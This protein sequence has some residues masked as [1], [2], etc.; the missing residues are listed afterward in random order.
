LKQLEDRTLPS[1]AFAPHVDYPVGS[2]PISVAVGDF[3]GNGK[4]DLA[5]VN[6]GSNSV[7][8]LMGNGDGTFQP[9]VNYTVGS[10]PRW[11][12]V[13][14]FR[15]DGKL[16]LAVACTGSNG[17]NI[18]LGNGDGTFQPAQ[19]YPADTA[20]GAVAVGDFNGD[21]NLD[22]AV[23]NGGGDVSILLGNGDGTFQ[24]PR[25]FA[26]DGSP[27]GIAVADL[28]HDGKLDVVTANQTTGDFSVLLGSGDGTLQAAQNYSVG[29][30]LV[31]VVV[32][33][34]NGDGKLDIA[35]AKADI[36]GLG[37]DSV[38]L[39]LGNGD[40]TFQS[41]SYLSGVT[42]PRRLA[43]GDFTGDG[44]EDLAVADLGANDV[45]VFLGNGDGSFQAAQ[46]FATG[47]APYA[48]A[49]GDFNG[50]GKPDLAVVNSGGNT[51]SVLLNTT[52]IPTLTTT[53]GGPVVLGSGANL[54]DSATLSGGYNPTGTITFTLTAPGGAT[55]DTETV[56]V[57]G[58]GTYATPTGYL[59]GAA[60]TYEWGATY[61]GDANNAA[62]ANSSAD[63]SELAP[64]PT[65]REQPAADV[66]NG[67]LYVA[68]GYNGRYLGTLEVYNPAT[69]SWTTKAPMPTPRQGVT[70]GVIN[71]LLYVAGGNGGSGS[72][73]TLQVYDPSTD[74]WTTKTSMPMAVEDPEHSAVVNGIL[75][76]IGGNAGGFCTNAVQAYGPT[77]DT[78]S[79]KSP[80]PTQR[81]H[82]S[83]VALNGLI[84]AMGGTDTRGTAY[85]STVEVYNPA[86][87]SW[88]T[89]APMPT[90][91]EA[92][93][94]AVVNNQVLVMGGYN[95]PTGTLVATVQAYDPSTNTWTTLTP[96]PTARDNLVAGV[97]NGV[98]YAVGG[99]NPS[100]DLATNEGF[101]PGHEAETVS[102]ANPTIATTAGGTVVAGSGA[103][104][105][106][107]AT[108]SG[109][110]NPTGTISFSLTAPDGA[111]VD[112]ETATVNGDGT[113]TTPNGYVPGAAGT[114]QWVASYGGDPNNNPVASTFGT[115][116]ESVDPATA[117]L[118]PS[119]TSEGGGSFNLT[120]NGAGFTSSSAVQWN[121]AALA[122][123][124]V[125]AAEVQAAVPASDLAEEGSA[126]IA[127]AQPT[128]ETSA[129]QPLPIGDA[130]LTATGQSVSGSEGGSTG[131]VTVATFTDLGGPEAVGDYSATINWGDQASSTG[132]IVANAD[133][134]FSVQGSHTYADEGSYNVQVNLTDDGGATASASSTGSV[135]DVLPMAAIGGTTD[136]FHGVQ[137]QV[138]TFILSATD[139]SPVDTA[140][141][142]TYQVNWGDGSA[143]N[144]D[145]QTL[146]ATANNGAGVAA[147]HVY[148]A[149]GA[150]SVSVTATDDEGVTGPAA[151]QPVA[152]WWPS[153][154]AAT[155]WWPARRRTTPSSSIPALLP[156]RCK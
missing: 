74:S 107:S 127:V 41:P 70:A 28:K 140:A 93:A 80:M 19:Y 8:V 25:N 23:A 86:T 37:S 138:R 27:S 73:G 145:L 146:S 78:W 45:S 129:A 9:A 148:A 126:I 121:G 151:T 5:V 67:Q 102:P 6:E 139:P 21:G 96:M 75:Y 110:Y 42:S 77:T 130:P 122:T 39:M 156:A 4:Q 14:D 103:A 24:A 147:L 33:D 63:W 11:V 88:T 79:T 16:D 87:D 106:D 134:S 141:G 128:G 59:P 115:E 98:L 144:P 30:D 49:V 3:A 2:S 12:A 101:M 118:S 40:G 154:K 38:V 62:A 120:V 52:T 60:G 124:F 47:S 32:G 112:M 68:G 31:S 92:A 36:A 99:Y 133:G 149:A 61:S 89:A 34:F 1:V 105:T 20:S 137:G 54:T 44:K 51:L 64:M 100:G 125:S 81:C 97:V 57:N 94:A 76:V 150:Y 153:S 26:A 117:S 43:A 69:N 91:T 84:Y 108:L 116:P 143:L 48:V 83:V 135:S 10:D 155:C 35:G 65:A 58:N 109:G 17:V 132:T 131:T 85:Y 90:P 66:I 56:S 104:L 113:Y 18:L 136:G 114:Y 29:T 46:S 119:S 13:G 7:S 152:S 72:L 82:L 111:T 95:G 22:L 142:F 53:P 71:G 55:V 15:H 50:D 123:T